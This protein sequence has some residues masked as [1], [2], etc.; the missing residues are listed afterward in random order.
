MV[1]PEAAQAYADITDPAAREQALFTDAVMG[2]PA[3]WIAGKTSRS[4]SYLYRFA[5]VPEVQRASVPG[6]GHATEI[7]FVFDSW[8][9]LGAVGMGIKPSPADLAMTAAIHGCWVSFAK[10]GAPTCPGAPAWPAYASEK[11]DALLFAPPAPTVATHFN[12]AHYDALQAAELKRA[13]IGQ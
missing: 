10:T 5:Y 2:G 12:A 7:P 9:H 1:P 3:R 11:D 13:G 6:A 4:P 8:N